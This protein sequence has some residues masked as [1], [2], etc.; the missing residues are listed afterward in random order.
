MKKHVTH[1]IALMF[2]LGARS[3]TCIFVLLLSGCVS[4][5]DSR[6][7]GVSTNSLHNSKDVV[8]T[9]P[10]WYSDASKYKAINESAIVKAKQKCQDAPYQLMDVFSEPWSGIRVNIISANIVCGSTLKSVITESVSTTTQDAQKEKSVITTPAVTQGASKESDQKKKC[11][12][13]GLT[14]SSDDYKLCINS[15]GK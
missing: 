12:R 8:M 15:Q 10:A 5:P 11:L 9:F 1:S 4:M 3:S 14:P 6:N 2:S 7:L 13:M